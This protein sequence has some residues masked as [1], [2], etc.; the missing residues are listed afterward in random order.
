M[1]GAELWRWGVGADKMC[2]HTFNLLCNFCQAKLP[3]E[4]AVK[5]VLLKH[6][7]ASIKARQRS[8]AT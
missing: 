8:G 1:Y 7:K 6:K 4:A 2:L 3:N 5:K